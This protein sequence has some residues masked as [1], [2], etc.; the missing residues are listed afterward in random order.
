MELLY[1]P[2]QILKPQGNTGLHFTGTI[3]EKKNQVLFIRMALF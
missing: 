2:L 1:K 3:F